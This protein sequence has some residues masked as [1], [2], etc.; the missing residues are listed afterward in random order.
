MM[1][2]GIKVSVF[3]N[4]SIILVLLLAHNVYFRQQCLTRFE[5][6]IGNSGEMHYSCLEEKWSEVSG[7]FSQERHPSAGDSLSHSSQA[8]N[9]SEK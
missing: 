1:N 6:K 7:G 9:I 3:H 2:S 4:I 5:A 8:G